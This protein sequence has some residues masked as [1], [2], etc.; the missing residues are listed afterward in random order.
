MT[1]TREQ[2]ITK[3]LHSK[4]QEGATVWDLMHEGGGTD[5]RK[6]ISNLRHKGVEITDTWERN[7]KLRFK[8]YYLSEYYF[9]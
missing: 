4:G 6:Y 1:Q 5:V 2:I 9:I 3:V 7:G 8:R